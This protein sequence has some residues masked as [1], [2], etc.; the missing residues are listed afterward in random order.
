MTGPAWLVTLTT[1]VALVLLLAI[2]LAALRLVRGPP[3][4]DR[5]VALDLITVLGTGLVA[6]LALL[7]NS[8]L[9]LDV[10]LALALVGFLGTV[11]LARYIAVRTPGPATEG[12]NDG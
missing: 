3:R 9:Y 2:V 6:V 12:E 7:A 8:A 1:G 11:A 4:A 5:A 10:A